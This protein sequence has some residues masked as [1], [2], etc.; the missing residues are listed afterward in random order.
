MSGV[1]LETVV[2]RYGEVQVIHGVDLG[3]EDGEFCV[4][5]GPLGLREVDAPQDGR[6]ARGDDGRAASPSAGATSR[7]S[8]RPSG[9]W[10]WCSRPTRS[11]R[12]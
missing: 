7:G 10:R 12:T 11:T 8:T 6:G 3:I 1:T 2:K 5:V 9:A 4:F